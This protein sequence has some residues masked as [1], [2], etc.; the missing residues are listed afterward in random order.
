MLTLFRANP[1]E[2]HGACRTYGYAM[3][4]LQAEIPKI[5]SG[6]RIVLLG[7]QLDYLG[8]AF[9]HTDTVLIT[10]LLVNNNKSHVYAPI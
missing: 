7:I 5:G 6:M 8:R 1:V 2:F 10:F 9:R 4:A 3:A